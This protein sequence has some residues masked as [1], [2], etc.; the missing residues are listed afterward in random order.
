LGTALSFIR[1]QAVSN[2]SQ[3]ELSDFLRERTSSIGWCTIFLQTVDKPI[4]ASAMQDE[5][6][7]RESHHWWKA[8][9]WAY[10]N[11]NRLYIRYPTRTLKD[12]FAVQ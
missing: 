9:K 1:I 5:F 6:P 11:L 12:I 8:K 2:T 7:E 3:L 10:F 4:P